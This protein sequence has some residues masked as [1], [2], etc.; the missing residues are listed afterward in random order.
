MPKPKLEAVETPTEEEKQAIAKPKKFDLNKFKSKLDPDI[1]GTETLLTALPHMAIQEA[2]DY[3]RLH[4][5]REKYWSAELCF[6]NVPCKGQKRDTLHLIE[7]EIAV[8]FVSSARIR[9]F[10]L[11]LAS[12]PFNVFFLC[13]VPTRNFDNTWVA[14]NVQ[15]CEQATVKWVEI[16][17]RRDEGIEA[18]RVKP[19]RDPDAFSKPD[20]TKQPLDELIGITFAGRMIDSENHPGLLRIIGAKQAIS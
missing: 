4:P 8:C 15:G 18:Y 20:W 10:C 6:V 2:G 16:T 19:A 5:D 12:K 9:R 17:S 3:V 13:H 11:A 7:E 14:S 1:A